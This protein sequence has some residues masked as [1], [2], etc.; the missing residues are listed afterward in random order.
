ML[1]RVV[2]TIYSSETIKHLVVTVITVRITAVL[3]ELDYQ[4]TSAVLQ[5]SEALRSTACFA[6][7]KCLTQAAGYQQHRVVN[8][9]L[10][11]T[12]QNSWCYIA[13][14]PDGLVE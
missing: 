13:I 2:L 11:S 3:Q 5:V 8:T 1:R 6:W 7:Y 14:D 10:M 12:F 9:E 4:C